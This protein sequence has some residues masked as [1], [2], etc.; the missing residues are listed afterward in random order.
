MPSRP[1]KPCLRGGCRGYAVKGSAY[2]PEHARQRAREYNRT[3]ENQGAYGTEW[4]KVRAMKVR[5]NPLC[6]DCEQRGE[7]RQTAEVHHIDGNP[8]NNAWGNLRAM[9]RQCHAATRV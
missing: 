1:H 2:C 3:R 5:A 9:C 8:F 7:Y 4:Q 6:E